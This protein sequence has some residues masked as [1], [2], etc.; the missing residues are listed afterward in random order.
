V[1]EE[2]YKKI[3][4][5]PGQIYADQNYPGL[6]TEIIFVERDLSE[7]ERSRIFSPMALP[8]VYY[9]CYNPDTG[10]WSEERCTFKGEWQMMVQ[11]G[12]VS[13]YENGI[14]RAKRVINET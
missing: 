14:Q 13:L 12:E 11:S 6:L 7:A 5:T 8:Q 9:K 3:I 10:L 2:D 4:I 1:Y